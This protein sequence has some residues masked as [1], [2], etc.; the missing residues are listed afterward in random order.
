MPEPLEYWSSKRKVISPKPESASDVI[1][2][3]FDTSLLSTQD[4]SLYRA[5]IRW[6]ER[7]K[8]AFHVAD[9]GA[10]VHRV[11]TIWIQA[12]DFQ[13]ARP[14]VDSHCRHRNFVESAWTRNA[15]PRLEMNRV[16]W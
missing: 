12:E 16:V 14:F 8:I 9:D 10:L 6:L 1:P 4:R 2:K 7:E 5:V 3:M 11:Q 15:L 13:K